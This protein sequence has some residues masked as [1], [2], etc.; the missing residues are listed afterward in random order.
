MSKNNDG[1]LGGGQQGKIG[2]VVAYKVG[3]QF[4]YRGYRR[5]HRKSNSKEA[6][7]NHGH[8]GVLSHIA[9]KFG[10]M[11]SFTLA[12]ATK[13]DKVSST[14]HMFVRLNS[15]NFTADDELDFLHLKLG[16]GKM[17]TVA[18][19]NIEI[20]TANAM[21][22]RKIDFSTMND[23]AFFPTDLILFAIYFKES[24][25]AIFGSALR[26][27]NE[28]TILSQGRLESDTKYLYAVAVNT[29]EMETTTPFGTIYPKESSKTT[30][31]T[32]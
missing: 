7:Q 16:D 5:H 24:D 12:H 10:Y 20:Q 27:Q 4:R 28:V 17:A 25:E 2:P 22:V 31:V 6:K 18:I 19:G 9:S 26:G 21:T 13:R 15:G 1:I 30:C 29:R 23:G 14:H 32:L 8:F 3:D 11:T